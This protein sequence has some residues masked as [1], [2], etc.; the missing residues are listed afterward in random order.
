MD[1]ASYSTSTSKTADSEPST[2]VTWL[3][4]SR[5]PQPALFGTTR[6]PLAPTPLT[7]KGSGSPSAPTLAANR[8]LCAL[9]WPPDRP[10]M[11]DPMSRLTTVSAVV[12]PIR[13]ALP[14]LIF[15][16]TAVCFVCRPGWSDT[17]ASTMPSCV[18]W[19]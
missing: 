3:I 13:S 12:V 11:F 18:A 9:V 16:R 8:R 10:K 14:A 15:N 2:S 17:R 6:P 1:H 19:S 4:T 7:K 5:V